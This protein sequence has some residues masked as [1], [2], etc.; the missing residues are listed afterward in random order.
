[1]DEEG[2]A[3]PLRH[4]T[5]ESQRTTNFVRL[6]GQDPTR[7]TVDER[8]SA[9]C[10]TSPP[11]RRAASITHKF[12]VGGHEGYLTVGIYPD[13]R[14]R[15]DLHHH[16]E[17]RLDRQRPD[18]QL[19]LAVSIALQHGV[20]LKLLC[21]KFAHTRFEPSGWSDNPDIG[22][23]S[24]SWITSSAGCSFASSPDSSRHSSMASVPNTSEPQRSALR[25]TQG[26]DAGQRSFGDFIGKVSFIRLVIPSGAQSKP[27]DLKSEFLPWRNAPLSST[28]CRHASDT[29]L[30]RHGDAPNLL[31]LRR[32]HDAER[33][34]LS[35]HELR[36]HEWVQ[37][38]VVG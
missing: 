11:A 7:R 2:A 9:H 28:G 3:A 30:D 35:L 26:H 31:H 32:D 29:E 22:L 38:E 5:A 1:M 16:G 34:L 25:K 10:S 37:L 15:R 13:G 18:G 24:R 20:P 6:G 19:R 21:D 4:R 17:G 23:P 14:A 8:P 27:R 12:T 33:K 36:K